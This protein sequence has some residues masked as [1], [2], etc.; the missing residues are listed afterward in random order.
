M[1]LVENPVEVERAPQ[2]DVGINSNFVFLGRLAAE[3]GPVLFAQ[4]AKAA[5][6]DAIFIGDGEMRGP[7]LEANADAVI[8]GLEVR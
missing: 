2:V 3:K 6:V 4:A 1:H 8:T 5:N 7:V